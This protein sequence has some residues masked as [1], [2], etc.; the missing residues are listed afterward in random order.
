MANTNVINTD[1]LKEAIGNILY[2]YL[3]S[4][5]GVVENPKQ[6]ALRLTAEAIEVA[7]KD[8]MTDLM[9]LSMSDQNTY[10]ESLKACKTLLDNMIKTEK[11]DLDSVTLIS[12]I[13]SRL[14]GVSEESLQRL[15]QSNIE[16]EN[17]AESN[18]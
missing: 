12:G 5:Q 18:E 7:E 10:I 2:Y 1:N 16:I 3:I 8:M 4:A 17:E 6:E 9:T 15:A 11:M 13:I 14:I